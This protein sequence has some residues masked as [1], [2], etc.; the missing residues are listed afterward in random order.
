MNIKLW[1]CLLWFFT[2][3]AVHAQPYGNEWINYGQSYYKVYVHEDGIYRIP[4]TALANAGITGVDPHYFQLFF[5]GQE[6]YIYVH[7]ENNGTFYTN[8][9][10]EFYGRRN[11]GELDNALYDTPSSQANTQYSLFN[12]SSAY[13]LTWNTTAGKRMIAENDI[14]FTPYLSFPAAWFY[15]TSMK[16]YTSTYMVGKYSYW[17]TL[18]QGT[19]DNALRHKHA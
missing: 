8:G 15:F 9:Y 19:N 11:D 16:D 18:R 3:L 7:G 1:F 12:D 4:Y 6:Q 2:G 14:N 17:R 5:R 10:I 13:F